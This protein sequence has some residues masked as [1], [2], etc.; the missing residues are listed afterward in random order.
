MLVKK[1]VYLANFNAMYMPGV[2]AVQ[3]KPRL[4]GYQA[5][6]HFIYHPKSF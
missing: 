3:T 1:K 5:H 6:L 4:R 2:G